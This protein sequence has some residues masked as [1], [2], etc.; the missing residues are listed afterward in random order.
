M[1]IVSREDCV[2]APTFSVAKR[3]RFRL[4]AQKGHGECEY[5][6]KLAALKVGQSFRIADYPH[7]QTEPILWGLP[8]PEW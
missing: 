1:Q 7:R 8:R 3:T 6:K 4:L 5:A 2:E